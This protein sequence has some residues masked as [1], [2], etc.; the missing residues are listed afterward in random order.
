MQR[1]LF[2]AE[3]HQAF[4]FSPIWI[5]VGWLAKLF[6]LSPLVAFHL[7]RI[8]LIPLLLWAANQW[9]QTYVPDWGRRK[10]TLLLFLFGAGFGAAA[11]PALSQVFGALNEAYWPMDLWVTEGFTFLTLYQ[12][13]HFIAATTLL[14][15][16]FHWYGLG[17]FM[18]KSRAFFFSGLS[19][20]ALMS[21]HP[22]H[23]PTVISVFFITLLLVF[24]FQRHVF[25]RALLGALL[26]G[27][28]A[29]PMILY[30]AGIVLYHPIAIG[31]AEQNITRLPYLFVVL[32]S[33]GA[34][35]PLAVFA[36]FRKVKSRDALWIMPIA[37]FIGQVLAFSLPITFN[38]RL[39]E[40]WMLPLSLL[41]FLALWHILRSWRTSFW[42]RRILISIV[43]TV[44]FALSPLTLVGTDLTFW[45]DERFQQ[46]PNHMYLEKS[47]LRLGD[48]LRQQTEKNVVVATGKIGGLYVP[49]WAGRTVVSGHPIETLRYNEKRDS[50][51]LAAE[52]SDETMLDWLREH[53]ADYLLWGEYDTKDLPF[54]PEQSPSLVRVF[55]DG[56]LTLY[57]LQSP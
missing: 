38:R 2:T 50:F 53:Q 8:L 41:A 29:A 51:L 21:F 14:I 19:L 44:V 52:R 10:Y 55:Q 5:A 15:L 17:V 13:P 18:E 39:T 12:S 34:L 22:F 30:Q 25:R 36:L 56:E 42:T 37:W 3:P 33:Y 28:L 16:V 11:Y 31:R 27:C 45:S 54:Q 6:Q 57:Q 40:G 43:G 20:L 32:I 49:A 4:L 7:A 23:L 46:P 48:W 1:D 26:I 24:F 35:I 9:L 47:Y